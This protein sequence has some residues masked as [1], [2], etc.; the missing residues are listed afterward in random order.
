MPI[1]ARSTVDKQQDWRQI[2][3][4]SLKTPQDI[5]RYLQLPAPPHHDESPLLAASQQFAARV[6]TPFLDLAEPGNPSDPITRQVLPHIDETVVDPLYSHDPLSEQPANVQPGIIHK[7]QGRALLLAATGCAVNC[8]YCFR[9]HFDYADNRIGRAQ[10][11]HALDYVRADTSLSEIILSGGD[12]LMLQDHLLSQLIQSL[13]SIPHLRRLRIHSRLP[14]VIPQRLTASLLNHL[15]NSRL[16]S[17]LVLHINH[18]NE[19]GPDLQTRL[20]D[21]AT[22]PVT[23]LNQSVLLKGVN[24]HVETLQQLSESLFDHGILP[25]YLHVLDKV[26]GAAHFDIPDAQALALYEQLHARLP[27]YLLPRLTREEPGKSG[28]TLLYKG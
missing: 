14:V 9:R 6:P 22:S 25:Y 4:Q 5:R 2:L 21:W 27:G 8:R 28:K 18:A 26:Q 15:S 16:K 20:P 12:P 1:I 3:A 7:Y 10:W 23:L 13:E 11:Q 17:T 24:D 19:I